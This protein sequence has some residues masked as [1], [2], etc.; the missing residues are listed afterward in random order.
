[1]QPKDAKKLVE[2]D[3]RSSVL[4]CESF[5]RN[6]VSVEISSAQK[7]VKEIRTGLTEVK[8][9]FNDQ[10]ESAPSDQILKMTGI[11]GNTIDSK[12]LELRK[13]PARSQTRRCQTR[14]SKI[15]SKEEASRVQL[16]P[17]S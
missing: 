6:R 12:S 5:S 1:M 10:R 15:K 2:R 3:N 8:S 16:R 13:M 7:S 11:K 14:V 17:C 4:K 9:F